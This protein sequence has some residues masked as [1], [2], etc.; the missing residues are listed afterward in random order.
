MWELKQDFFKLG[1]WKDCKCLAWGATLAVFLQT[2]SSESK[3][4]LAF[5]VVFFPPPPRCVQCQH[6]KDNTTFFLEARKLLFQ[7]LLRVKAADCYQQSQRCWLHFVW[8]I[9]SGS[10]TFGEKI[11]TERK[12]GQRSCIDLFGEMRSSWQIWGRAK[13]LFLKELLL[14]GAEQFRVLSSSLHS[15]NPL[16]EF[17]PFLV[18]YWIPEWLYFVNLFTFLM[19]FLNKNLKKR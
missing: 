8:L 6:F 3:A 17:L 9:C 7:T 4:G 19:N 10:V 2:E 14:Y 18:T 13:E 15:V 5:L 16:T 12:H 1:K 11:Y